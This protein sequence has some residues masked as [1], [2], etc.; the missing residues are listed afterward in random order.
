[1]SEDLPLVLLALIGVT[2]S[3]IALV[4]AIAA[5]HR[6]NKIS[7]W[8]KIISEHHGVLPPEE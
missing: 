1:M 4:G 2:V 5:N 7:N 3:L 6:I 8:A